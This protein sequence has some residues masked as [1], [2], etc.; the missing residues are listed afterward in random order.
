MTA[1][2]ARH[3]EQPERRVHHKVRKVF[4]EACAL[5]APAT[6]QNVVPDTSAALILRERYPEL[7]ALEIHVLIT[8][9][10]R[11]CQQHPKQS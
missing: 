5:I 8:A 6:G 4:A 1:S 7:S 9:A 2:A 10:S 3:A 11:G